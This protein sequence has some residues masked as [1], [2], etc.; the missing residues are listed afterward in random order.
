MAVLSENKAVLTCVCSLL[1]VS[2]ES[3]RNANFQKTRNGRFGKTHQKNRTGENKVGIAYSSPSTSCLGTNQGPKNF[4]EGSQAWV[5]V[6]IV[7]NIGSGIWT[8]VFLPS[9]P[10]HSP[11]CS[12]LATSLKYCTSS[13]LFHNMLYDKANPL[14]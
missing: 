10:T 1:I 8:G 4:R 12:H 14:N 5:E 2:S 13:G 11:L 6:S 9:H 3:R 7:M